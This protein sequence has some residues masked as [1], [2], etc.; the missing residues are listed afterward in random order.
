MLMVNKVK[1]KTK[2]PSDLRFK[3]FMIIFYLLDADFQK[4]LIRLRL[5]DV[6]V[7]LCTKNYLE[8]NAISCQWNLLPL[9]EN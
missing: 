1:T 3:F 9:I 4:R 5:K 2:A 8:H 6:N 7:C